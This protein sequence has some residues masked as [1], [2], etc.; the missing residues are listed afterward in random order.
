MTQNLEQKVPAAGL[1]AWLGLETGNV[2][3]YLIG[4]IPAYGGDVPQVVSSAVIGWT[5]LGLTL[6][7]AW[8]APHTPRPD[9]LGAR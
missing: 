9:L 2:L 4:L 3:V 8:L 6:L 5:I 1:G 7:S